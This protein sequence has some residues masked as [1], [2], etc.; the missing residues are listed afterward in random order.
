MSTQVKRLR[1]PDSI[2]VNTLL[3]H[4]EDGADIDRTSPTTVTLVDAPD[5][6]FTCE[7]GENPVYSLPE[8]A[9]E[10]TAPS[11]TITL[12]FYDNRGNDIASIQTLQVTQTDVRGGFVYFTVNPGTE[13]T[14][15][16][17]YIHALVQNDETGADNVSFSNSSYHETIKHVHVYAEESIRFVYWS[18]SNEIC[19]MEQQES[20]Q[21][22]AEMN[23]LR[24]VHIKTTGLYSETVYLRISDENHTLLEMRV[25]LHR[26]HRTVTVSMNDMLARYCS[27]NNLNEVIDQNRTVN[28]KASVSHPFVRDSKPVM[29]IKT[30]NTMELN[31]TA[32]EIASQTANNGAVPV[33]VDDGR[34]EGV[35]P[36]HY[37]DFTIGYMC[38]IEGVGE[39]R[40][41]RT[42]HYTAQGVDVQYTV[43][44]FHVYEIKL[45]DLV[46]CGL[47]TLEEASYLTTSDHNTQGLHLRK[48]TDLE[49]TFNKS[50]A[51]LSDTKPLICLF[52]DENNNS[53]AKS[54]VIRKV[55]LQVHPKET[56]F[57]VDGESNNVICRDA[58]QLVS[59]TNVVQYRREPNETISPGRYDKNMECPFGEFFLNYQYPN[60]NDKP[61]FRVY[62]S[63]ISTGSN[64]QIYNESE[65][66]P[67]SPNRRIREG[68]AFHNGGSNSSTGCLTFNLHWGQKGFHNDFHNKVFKRGEEIVK[69]IR[70]L[71]FVCIDERNAIQH[72]ASD[73]VTLPGHRNSINFYRYYDLVKASQYQDQNQE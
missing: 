22:T 70:Q 54:S 36:A 41:C 39:V 49:D 6:V 34:I 38:H 66:H 47:V 45:S 46:K 72:E 63:R 31:V 44:P 37:T 60:E 27:I 16:S 69:N 25:P 26:N 30:G 15:T 12:N 43:Y 28:L 24:Y 23:D 52:Q 11:F 14:G 8:N 71:N 17:F 18:D 51:M 57:N 40:D 32:I 4:P 56:C 9:E 53:Y 48:D 42:N 59:S 1:G 62:A 20:L 55:L 58:W 2:H 73:P 13:L 68:I 29:L 64:I 5:D 35:I 21:T 61:K 7:I 33:V 50:E 19:D 67:D 3:P 65:R 10:G